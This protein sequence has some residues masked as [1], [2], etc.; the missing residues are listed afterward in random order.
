M[1][2]SENMKAAD[3]YI[4]QPEK[5]AAE[6]KNEEKKLFASFAHSWRHFCAC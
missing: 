6:E 3:F 5:Q 4:E 2:D 1:G